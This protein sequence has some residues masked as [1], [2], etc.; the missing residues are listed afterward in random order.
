[1]KAT[2]PSPEGPKGFLGT[3]LA[4]Q[5]RGIPEDL[6]ESA[7]NGTVGIRSAGRRERGAAGTQGTSGTA[8]NPKISRK[9]VEAFPSGARNSLPG[10]EGNPTLLPKFHRWGSAKTLRKIMARTKYSPGIPHRIFARKVASSSHTRRGKSKDSFPPAFSIAGRA[11]TGRPRAAVLLGPAAVT[12]PKNP[13]AR[14]WRS[15]GYR[16]HTSVRGP[17]AGPPGARHSPSRRRCLPGCA[18]RRP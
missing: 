16:R 6:D 7:V 9:Q 10:L 12:S 11:G 18:S 14:P 8:G 4:L 2:G 5:G 13:P 17:G 3:Q 15:G 1:M